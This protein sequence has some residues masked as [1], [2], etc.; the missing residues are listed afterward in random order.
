[1]LYACDQGP[2]SPVCGGS[3]GGAGSGAGVE[4]GAGRAWLATAG[5]GA[6]GVTVGMRGF[7]AWRRRLTTGAGD[8]GGRQR[9]ACAARSTGAG[10]WAR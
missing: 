10:R 2:N 3:E 9:G 7:G 1:M 8:G 4:A 6:E 5:S